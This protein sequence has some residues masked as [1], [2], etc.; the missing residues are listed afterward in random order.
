MNSRL[1]Q[2]RDRGSYLNRLNPLLKLITVFILCLVSSKAPAN[3]VFITAAVLVVLYAANK[4]P[5]S[6]LFKSGRVFLVIA[7]FIAISEYY[8]TKNAMQTA[9]AVC[10]YLNVI[11]L[12][13]IFTDCTSAFDLA[14][15]FGKSRFGMALS[16]SLSM[17]PITVETISKTMDSGRARGASFF[18]SP[19]S[20]TQL[21]VKNVI[22]NLLEK[23]SSY[24]DALTARCFQEES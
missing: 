15:V 11:L 9:T 21:L 6:T 22:L 12:S 5:L 4:I 24:S 17:L 8:N 2:Y 10:R 7:L 18:R 19:V 20:Y 13:I 1:F 3:V 23:V 14:R 16:L